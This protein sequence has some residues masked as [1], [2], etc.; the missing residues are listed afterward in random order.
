MSRASCD[1]DPCGCGPP[2]PL[3]RA[4]PTCTHP[5]AYRAQ[6]DL[7]GIFTERTLAAL[8]LLLRTSSPPVELVRSLPSLERLAV[9]FHTFSGVGAREGAEYLAAQCVH[10]PRLRCIGCTYAASSLVSLDVYCRICRSQLYR[11]LDAYVVHAP[12]QRHISYELH[13]DVP[14]LPGAVAA[15]SGDPSR[16]HCARNCQGDRWLVDGGS[17]FVRHVLGRRYAIAC[18]SGHG[19]LGLSIAVRAGAEL[20]PSHPLAQQVLGGE[21]AE[22]FPETVL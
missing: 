10:A 14:P 20:P 22:V 12:Q 16:L 17:G 3:P 15:L 9:G 2:R 4:R 11:A 7:R 8:R 13:T 6:L 19:N 18:G 21:A 1:A 5:T